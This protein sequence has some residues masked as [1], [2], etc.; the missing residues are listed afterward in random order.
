VSERVA[1]RL[2]GNRG[3]EQTD[4]VGVAKD[5]RTTLAGWPNAGRGQSSTNERVQ[6]R[7]AAEILEWSHR[8]DKDLACRC[9]G[10]PMAQIPWMNKL[11][12]AALPKG[13]ERPWVARSAEGLL[14]LRP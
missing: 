13:S 1:D 3:A 11:D 8:A 5:M 7:A 14:V 10:T 2:H 4:S 12:P 6:R 9:L